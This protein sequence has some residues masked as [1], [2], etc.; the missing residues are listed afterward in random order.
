MNRPKGDVIYTLRKFVKKTK[1]Q[2]PGAV[3]VTRDKAI[4]IEYKD[5]RLERLK[6]ETEEA[7]PKGGLLQ[8]RRLV[9]PR[10]PA[11][12]FPLK[13]KTLVG[14]RSKKYLLTIIT[15]L[16]PFFSVFEA[17]NISIEL[18]V[19]TRLENLP[20]LPTRNQAQFKQVSS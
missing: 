11:F 5:E 18:G 6:G 12:P 10:P 2:K 17:L 9:S 15:F 7:R 14:A 19:E 13:Q 8:I 16:Y 20:H 4:W 1:D 3:Q